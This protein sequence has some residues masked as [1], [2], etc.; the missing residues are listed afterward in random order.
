MQIY[1]NTS[2]C[3]AM[4]IFH[5]GITSRQFLLEDSTLV[6][7]GVGISSDCAEVLRDYNESVKSVDDLSY[8]ANQK[9][10]GEPKTWG[11]RSSKDSCLQRALKAQQNQA[12]K[13]GS[14]CFFK[15]TTY[16]MLPLMPWFLG[17]YTKC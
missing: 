2:L 10:G 14:R 5:S 6:K 4:H 11:L 9:L 15:R 1:G 7:V 3:H 17:N 12:W 16:N 13:L 8:H